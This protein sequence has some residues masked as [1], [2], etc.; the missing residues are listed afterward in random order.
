M[1]SIYSA[2]MSLFQYRKFGNHGQ[3]Y[4]TGVPPFEKTVLKLLY[5]K[6]VYIL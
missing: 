3:K 1:A 6:L 4:C 5:L 2:Y